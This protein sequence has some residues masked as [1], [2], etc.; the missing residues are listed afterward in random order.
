MIPCEPSFVLPPTMTDVIS[1]EPRFVLPTSVKIVPICVIKFNDKCYGLSCT[2]AVF[3]ND[4]WSY[5]RRVLSYQV[6]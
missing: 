5:T 6:Q 4:T 3:Y 2:G 1:N